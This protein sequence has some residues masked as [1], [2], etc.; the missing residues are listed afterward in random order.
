MAY[1]QIL[2]SDLQALLDKYREIRDV[3][4]EPYFLCPLVK[5]DIP[6]DTFD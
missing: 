6:I 5:A 4:E 3:S 1:S 2:R